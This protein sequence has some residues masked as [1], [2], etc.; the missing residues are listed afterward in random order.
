MTYCYFYLYN[1]TMNNSQDNT[2]DYCIDNYTIPELKNIFG[3]TDTDDASSVRSKIQPFFISSANNQKMFGF[4]RDAQHEIFKNEHIYDST[5][6]TFMNSQQEYNNDTDSNSGSESL[7]TDN[8][9]DDNDFLSLPGNEHLNSQLIIPPDSTLATI[10]DD[11]QNKGN[12]NPLTRKIQT[13]TMCIDSIFKKPNESSSSF[14]VTFPK[15]IEN[16]VSMSLRHIDLPEI[17]YN[18]TDTENRNNIIITT[19]NLKSLVST[20]HNVVVPPGDYTATQISST[21]NNIFSNNTKGLQYL[22]FEVDPVSHHSIIRAKTTTDTGF[23][24]FPYDNTNTNTNTNTYSPDF[25][26]TVEFPSIKV[27]ADLTTCDTSPD[28]GTT[29]TLHHDSLGW[30]LGFRS[31]SLSANYSDTHVNNTSVNGTQIVYRAYLSSKSIF[32]RKVNEYIFLDINDFHNNYRP[33]NVISMTRNDYIGSTIF[34][35]IPTKRDPSY[36]IIGKRDYFGPVH[37]D[38]LH[39]RLLTKQG[40]LITFNDTNFS[41]ALEF[42]MQY[43]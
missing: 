13:C 8:N 5:S 11:I 30:L 33:D 32:T 15:T 43:S 40:E 20:T 34:S 18:V 2:F 16:V 25:Y 17:I 19:H 35:R 36:D 6:Q 4:F 26:Y 37:I 3:I 41:M 39:I 31:V 22:V 28:A 7:A 12:I 38:K 29:Q 1:I 21:I 24:Y 14:M 10:N 23:P 27:N 42:T 9:D